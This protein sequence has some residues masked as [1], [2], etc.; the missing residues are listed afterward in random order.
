MLK[1]RHKLGA[2]ASQFL[3]F[4]LSTLIILV[5]FAAGQVLVETHKEKKDAYSSIKNSILNHLAIATGVY[6]YDLSHY[7]PLMTILYILFSILAS[8][9]LFRLILAIMTTI[10]INEAGLVDGYAYSER[11][12]LI[13]ELE[14][15]CSLKSRRAVWAGMSMELNVEFDEGDF[16]PEGGIQVREAVGRQMSERAADD[17]IKR[18]P[19]ECNPEKAWPITREA[20]EN[21]LEEQFDKMAG[22]T[23]R[24][25]RNLLTLQKKAGPG[26]KGGQGLPTLS[27]GESGTSG[28]G[29]SEGADDE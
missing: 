26:G 22:V 12:E 5:G 11:A 17:R 7:N 23:E 25:R 10:T 18:F 14:S 28:Q 2:V 15:I 4:I 20:A 9:I 21:T 6:K 16:G 19:G 13:L 3:I 24:M 8:F 29:E 27:E 1:F